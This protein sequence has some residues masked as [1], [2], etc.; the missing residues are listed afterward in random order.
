[1]KQITDLDYL[2]QPLI[3]GAAFVIEDNRIKITSPSTVHAETSRVLP[4]N[5]SDFMTLYKSVLKIAKSKGVKISYSRRIRRNSI[6][7]WGEYTKA[8][9]EADELFDE[10]IEQ[11]K[12][13]QQ[14]GLY[15][16]TR[17]DYE[18]TKLQR[19]CED[20]RSYFYA[21]SIV[22]RVAEDYFML[23]SISQRLEKSDTEE[24]TI[25]L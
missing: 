13:V 24:L 12:I 11:A 19:L 16:G 25:Y 6:D 21:T 4:I 18:L 20:N 7:K 15:Y 17:D 1:M 22:A 3:E 8:C 5:K 10:V 23:K 2:A 9:N 14:R